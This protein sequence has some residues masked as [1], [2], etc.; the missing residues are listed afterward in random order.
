MKYMNDAKYIHEEV[1]PLSS[2]SVGN[3]AWKGLRTVGKV[4]KQGSFEELIW[5]VRSP[6]TQT[7]QSK[8]AFI[9]EQDGSIIA[10]HI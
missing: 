7:R 8:R 4:S 10:L 6:T 2:V 3:V 5:V 1:Q 9:S